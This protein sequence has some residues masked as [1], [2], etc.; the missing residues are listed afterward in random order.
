MPN[1]HVNFETTP[2][3]LNDRLRPWPSFL[4]PRRA[5]VSS[6]GFGGVNAHVVLEA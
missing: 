4:T 6:F 1:R 3:Y 5:G 2:F